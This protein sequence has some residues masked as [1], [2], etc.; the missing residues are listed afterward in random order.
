MD[1]TTGTKD[2]RRV[3]LA[4]FIGGHDASSYVDPHLLDFSF[5]DNAGGKADE[6]QLSLHDRDG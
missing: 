2:A 3:T 6:I 5:K 1:V 4:V